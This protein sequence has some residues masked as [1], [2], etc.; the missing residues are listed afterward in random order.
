[1][2]QVFWRDGVSK[3][4][5]ERGEERVSMTHSIQKNQKPHKKSM[6]RGLFSLGM[7]IFFLVGFPF[8]FGFPFSVFSCFSPKHRFVLCVCDHFW[9]ISPSLSLFFLSFVFC[10]GSC[11]LRWGVLSSSLFSS[12]CPFSVKKKLLI[13]FFLL[14]KIALALIHGLLWI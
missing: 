2:D 8:W 14:L 7:K 12:F 10:W 1:M 9:G 13:S 5:K 4:L 3:T 11:I 6:R